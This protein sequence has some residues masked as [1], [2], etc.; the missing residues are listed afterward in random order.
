MRLQ[1][2]FQI[3]QSYDDNGLAL[4]SLTISEMFYAFGVLFVGCELGHRGTSAFESHERVL[5]EFDWHS[6]PVK[7]QQALPV[8]FAFSQKPVSFQC[9]GSISCNRISLKQVGMFG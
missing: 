5:V 4:L 7:L 9:F 3:L 8:V 1:N 6:F 2:R